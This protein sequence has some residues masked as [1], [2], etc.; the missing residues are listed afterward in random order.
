MG[1]ALWAITATLLAVSLALIVLSNFSE[2]QLV[3]S[4]ELSAVVSETTLFKISNETGIFRIR[5]IEAPEDVS[6]ILLAGRDYEKY[7]MNKSIPAAPLILKSDGKREVFGLFKDEL[8]ILAKPYLNGGLIQ[9]EISRYVQRFP[10]A[11]LSV[12]GYFLFIVSLGIV[13]C[14]VKSRL[15]SRE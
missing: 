8:A 9:V 14:L 7:A 12:P 15:E 11:F 13:L 5:L 6:L 10:Y 3:S 1:R 2:Y 4:A